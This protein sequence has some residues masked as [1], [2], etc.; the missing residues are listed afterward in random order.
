M[1]ELAAP[2]PRRD[3]AG[4]WLLIAAGFASLALALNGGDR[5]A[6]LAPVAAAILF[7]GALAL[8]RPVVPWRHVLV[9]LVLVILF[10]PIRRYR[11]P[12]DL[13]FELEPYRVL[14]ALILAGWGAA[15]LVDPRVTL[16]RSGFERPLALIVLVVF[17]SVLANPGEVG[18]VES[19]VVKAIMFLLS[20]I[21]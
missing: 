21:L 20:F 19:T 15:L 3:L 5:A 14:V 8:R 13:S 18:A 10:I 17:A 1:G 7:L 9:A 6:M 12:V 2:Q 16:R 11:L 4:S